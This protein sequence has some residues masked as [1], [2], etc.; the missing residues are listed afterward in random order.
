MPIHRPGGDRG[1]VFAY[2]QEL[3]YWLRNRAQGHSNDILD[4]VGPVLVHTPPTPVVAGVPREHH[5][6]FSNPNSKTEAS[7]ALVV[8]AEAMGDTISPPNF[9]V[10]ARIYREAIYLDFDNAKAFAGL[11]HT[12][13]MS[14]L[15]GSLPMTVGY[16]AARAAARKALEIDPESHDA[17]CASGW[18]MM[19]SE[20]N[21]ELAQMALNEEADKNPSSMRALMGRALLHIAE[22]RPAAGS[23]LLLQ[24]SRSEV[25]PGS[26]IAL[27][28]WCEFLTRRCE[29][30]LA[31]L[32]HGRVCG[33]SG[34]LLDAVEALALVQ[35]VEYRKHM[36][37]IEAMQAASSTHLV[38]QGALGYAHGRSGNIAAARRILENLFCPDLHDV[39]EYAYPIALV[40]VGL[41]ENHK[42]VEWL[43]QSYR[44]GSI[45]SLG[46]HSDPILATM[47]HD[48]AYKLLMNRIHYPVPA[49][50][51]SEKTG[52]NQYLSALSYPEM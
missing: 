49:S 4:H 41:N 28:S 47:R 1:S 51:P 11:S 14:T 22:G 3:D 17:K 44:E 40:L 36:P 39:S 9:D 5:Q 52:T 33:H 46:F 23:S 12:L 50:P 8:R 26:A 6:S 30:A 29:K 7:A 38:L 16:P 32:S 2:T 43:E 31:I 10:I 45:W 18:L 35:S 34:P 42:A 13:I 24:A 37:R 21:W 19:L 15:M 27:R 25:L 48:P 20:R